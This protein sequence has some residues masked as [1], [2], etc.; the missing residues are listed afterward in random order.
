MI[1]PVKNQNQG[2]LFF[3]LKETLNS[4][5][6]LFLL[7]N[8][9]QWKIFE[10]AFKGLYSPD[11]GRPAKPIRLMVGLLILKHI[12][13]LSDESVVEQW[14]E[15]S[16]FQYFT[17]ESSFVPKY[18]CE[19]SE[20]VHFRKRIGE[21]GMELILKESIRINGQDSLDPNVNVDTTVQEKN[22]TFPTDAK[23][24][25]KIIQKCKNIAQ[26]EDIELRQSYNRILKKL[27]RDQ[28]FRNHPKNKS[29]A[30]KADKK[31][32]TIAGRLVRELS[33]KLP[34]KSQYQI[35]LELYSKI[36]KQ[37]KDSKN[38]I[39]S[40]HEPEVVCISKGKEYKKYEFGNKVSIAKTD[41]GVIVGA[42]GFRDQYDG[43]TLKPTL[44]QVERLVGKMPKK[45]KVDR[46]FKGNK[47]I[48][49]TEILIPTTP[50][51]SMSYY[52]MKKISDSH[53]KRAAIEPI[54]GHLKTDH[55]LNRNFYK[56]IVGDNI[57]IMLAAAAFNFK[58]IM[59]KWKKKIL[60]FF[61]KQFYPFQ[62]F[63]FFHFS[64][65]FFS[66]TKI[67]MTF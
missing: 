44:E 31:V 32:K 50:S 48:G 18:P 16:Y 11:N 33:R 54:I 60:Y 8:Q 64:F 2:S 59:N 20:L 35:D 56:G 13:N 6:P 1:P 42:L 46:G 51:K 3:T 9:I 43:H 63:T 39:Y 57:N 19:A 45:V 58:R 30:K 29:K 17:G 67:K 66:R 21:S 5:H 53:K 37:K 52:Q 40:I 36:L 34:P 27:S 41:S 62:I 10:N 15:N 49:E 14:S 22:I 61:Q 4:K 24:H 12:R 65:F 47:K 55:R 38:K 26:K 25:K 23:L 28:R 7:A